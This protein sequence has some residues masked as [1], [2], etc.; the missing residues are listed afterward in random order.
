MEDFFR[1]IANK[2][3]MPSFVSIICRGLSRDPIKRI[4]PTS[5]G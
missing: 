5:T 1:R 4:S 3:F 2:D